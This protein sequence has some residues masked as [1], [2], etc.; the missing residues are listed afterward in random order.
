VRSPRSFLSAHG[1]AAPRGEYD[2]DQAAMTSAAPLISN[3]AL[4]AVDAVDG[5]GWGWLAA[6]PRPTTSRVPPRREGSSVGSG[7]AAWRRQQAVVAE[8]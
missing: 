1:S 3:G 5:A 4:A 6:P 7:V 2:D 8:P